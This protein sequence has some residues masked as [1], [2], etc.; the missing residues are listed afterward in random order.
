MV[1]EC[2]VIVEDKLRNLLEKSILNM[3]IWV[4]YDEVKNFIA[5]RYR[6]SNES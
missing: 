6:F 1:A 5:E 4:M 2:I 3:L